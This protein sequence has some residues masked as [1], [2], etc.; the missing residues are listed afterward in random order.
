MGNWVMAIRSECAGGFRV[1]LQTLG[2][3]PATVRDRAECTPLSFA[4]FSL[5]CPHV[6]ALPTLT[7]LS[8]PRSDQL[9]PKKVE[10]LRGKRVQTVA[11]GWRHTMAADSEGVLYG[12][13]WNKVRETRQPE[14]SARPPLPPAPLLPCIVPLFM[15]LLQHHPSPP[16]SLA[17]A[18]GPRS[19]VS[20]AWATHQTA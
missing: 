16:S 13:G 12:W 14:P 15:P 3:S 11:G 20:W 5:H 8:L 2:T 17:S 6:P 10:A 19:L 7:A 1:Y 18:P 4:S 9:L